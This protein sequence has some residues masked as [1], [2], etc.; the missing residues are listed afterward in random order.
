MPD[1]NPKVLSD[2]NEHIE[3]KT[4]T[5]VRT[6]ADNDADLRDSVSLLVGGG[7]TDLK[8]E[9]A[10][11]NFLRIRTIL[12]DDQK[13][14]NLL[15]HIFLQNQRPGWQQMKPE[16]RVSSFYDINSSDK[17]TSELLQKIKSFGTGPVSG[18]TDS[19]NEVNQQQQGQ[20]LNPAL[21]KGGGSVD[22]LKKYFDKK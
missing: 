9:N 10:R 2:L 3:K 15:T 21:A 8:D 7:F 16:Q 14:Q 1:H 4:G 11:A 6:P 12:N 17:G 20:G 22:E 5:K 18:Y 19:V 13:A